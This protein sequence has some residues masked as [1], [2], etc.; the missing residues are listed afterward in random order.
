[1]ALKSINC[2]DYHGIVYNLEVEEDQTYVV[3]GLAV[4]NCWKVGESFV[5]V[6]GK[7][8]AFYG[9]LY[10]ERKQQEQERN[11]LGMF[12]EQ[13]AAMLAR[14]PKHKQAAIYK[15]G[16]LPDGHIHA[17]AKRYAVKLFLAHYFEKGCELAGRP[18]PLPYPI[19]YGEHVHT[20]AA[21]A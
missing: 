20:I 2:Q 5:K 10:V 13:A 19:A 15:T 18:V 7:E 14:N 12:A 16:K 11:N 1:M 8:D 9:Q 17:R 21:P 6:S 3:E 4:H